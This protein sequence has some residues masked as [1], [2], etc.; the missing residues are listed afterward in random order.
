VLGTG[1]MHVINEP[2]NGALAA[3]AGG[4]GDQVVSTMYLSHGRHNLPFVQI[5]GDNGFIRFMVVSRG[6]GALM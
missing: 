3:S 1:D 4:D 2:F 5:L 6:A